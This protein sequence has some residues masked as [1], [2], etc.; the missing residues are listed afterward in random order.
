MHR[1]LA[2]EMQSQALPVTFSAFARTLPRAAFKDSRSHNID[3]LSLFLLGIL[4]LVKGDGGTFI[5]SLYPKTH[6]GG[7]ISESTSS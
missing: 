7:K 3:N 1:G 5:N 2:T 4:I 6:L